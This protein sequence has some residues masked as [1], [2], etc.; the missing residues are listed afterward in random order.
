MA[1]GHFLCSE[2]MFS[3][4]IGDRFGDD[5]L[6]IPFDVPSVF[7][8]LRLVVVV[9]V[10]L[11]PFDTII[12]SSRCAYSR[13]WLSKYICSLSDCWSSLSLFSFWLVFSLPSKLCIFSG[14]FTLEKPQF[15]VR[16]QDIKRE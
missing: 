14:I 12:S 6:L 4:G 13:C 1:S 15:S 9:V 5:R 16:N 10:A 2:K 11:Q 3:V 8:L 7:K